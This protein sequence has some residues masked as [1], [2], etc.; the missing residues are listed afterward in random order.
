MPN[1]QDHTHVSAKI[2]YPEPTPEDKIL[3]ANV[4]LVNHTP[5]D[6]ALHFDRLTTP[7]KRPES[8]E[9][10]VE[11]EA[12]KIATIHIPVTLVRGLIEALQ[13][14]LKGYEVQYGKVTIPKKG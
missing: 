3:Y 12:T 4:I 10:Q 8:K 14:N 11:I 6:F 9:G 5:W 1:D 2:I 13:T 7:I